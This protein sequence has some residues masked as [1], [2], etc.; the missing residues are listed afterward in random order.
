MKTVLARYEVGVNG[1]SQEHFRLWSDAST[2]AIAINGYV[3]DRMARIGKAQLW[4]A[5]NGNLI[6]KAVRLPNNACSGQA[7]TPAE[8]GQVERNTP[9]PL[10]QTVRR[11]AEKVG[12]GETVTS[13]HKAHH[14]KTA[15]DN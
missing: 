14:Q 6:V 12:K 5:V 11:H 9:P 8:N 2:R 15:R 3:F 1:E 7:A 13:K 10:T 4:Q